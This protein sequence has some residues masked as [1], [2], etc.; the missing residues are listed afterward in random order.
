MRRNRAKD[1]IEWAVIARQSAER[2]GFRPSPYPMAVE[3]FCRG[4]DVSPIVQVFF[5]RVTFAET[6]PEALFGIDVEPFE[7]EWRDR[8]SRTDLAPEFESPALGLHV[9]NVACL[10]PRPWSANSPSAQDVA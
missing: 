3:T 9:A 8:L 7:R 6:A 4:G 2:A 1:P 5:Q 10:S